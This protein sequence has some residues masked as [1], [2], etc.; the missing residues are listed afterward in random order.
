MGKPYNTNYNTNYNTE[1]DRVM[2]NNITHEL[3]DFAN[4]GM[5]AMECATYSD[6]LAAI[7]DR[8]DMEHERRMVERADRYSELRAKMNNCYIELP[9]DADDVPWNIDDHDDD[10]NEVTELRL[11]SDGWFVVTDGEWSHRPET[12]RPKHKRHNY[13]L[14]VEDVMVEFA[15][16]WEHESDCMD[17]AALLKKYASKLK[18]AE[19]E[20]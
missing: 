20:D 18:L 14:T 12:Y 3:R 7:A 17:R 2:M 11:T 19:G 1:K 6:K 10:G 8:I 9:K 5:S 15:T 13:V 16:D 4:S